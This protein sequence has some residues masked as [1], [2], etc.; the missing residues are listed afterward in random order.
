[1]LIAQGDLPILTPQTVSVAVDRTPPQVQFKVSERAYHI[2][3]KIEQ[4]HIPKVAVVGL[5]TTDTSIQAA[6]NAAGLGSFDMTARGVLALPPY[7]FADLQI[8][9]VW[10]KLPLF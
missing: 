10:E 5:L 6:L 9:R 1:V 3:W 8:E 2:L 4:G 7:A